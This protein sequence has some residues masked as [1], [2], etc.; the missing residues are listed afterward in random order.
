MRSLTI[1]IG[2]IPPSVNHCYRIGGPHGLH[3]TPSA[4][5]F[6][7]HVGF[8]SLEVVRSC[9]WEMI[10]EGVFFNME[11]WF[12]FKNYKFSDPNNLLKVLIDS[13]EGIVFAND[14][15]LLPQVM[16]AKVTGRN[17]TTVVFWVPDK[18]AGDDD[19]MKKPLKKAMVKRV[20][21]DKKS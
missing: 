11:V 9:K 2:E 18:K 12:E 10:G 16:D 6:K 3:M 15:W 17:Y 20:K 4:V 5:K 19:A 8:T 13:F 14:K 21:G 1:K 7:D